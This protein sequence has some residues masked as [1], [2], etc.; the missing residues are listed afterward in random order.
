MELF[1]IISFTLSISVLIG[2][3]SSSDSSSSIEEQ[4]I[5]SWS[6]IYPNQC[7]EINVFNSDGT[8]SVTAL[9]EISSGTFQF[10]EN[11]AGGKHSLTVNILEDNGLADCNGVSEFVTGSVTIYASFPT[12]TTMNWY[13]LENDESP[14]ITV[15]K[16]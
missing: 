9:D 8:W 15:T 6:Y 4:L 2:C 1:K 11:S 10:V 12:D 3:G 13:L 7:E 16:K 14:D 5:G